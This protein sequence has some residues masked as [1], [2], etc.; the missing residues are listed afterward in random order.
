VI[1][2]QADEFVELILGNDALQCDLE[3]PNLGLL[4]RELFLLRSCLELSCPIAC[5]VFSGDRPSS[6]S[7]RRTLSHAGP[8][9]AT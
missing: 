8:T 6:R 5:V 3:R 1:V 7:A 9:A 2:V 4:L